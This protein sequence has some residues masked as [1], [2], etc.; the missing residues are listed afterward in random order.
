MAEETTFQPIRWVDRFMRADAEQP[1]STA[2]M[3]L[4]A[5]RAN[6]WVLFEWGKPKEKSQFYVFKKKEVLPRL[7]IVPP[8]VT[9]IR[10]LSL[11]SGPPSQAFENRPAGL[12]TATQA[13]PEQPWLPRKVLLDQVGKPVAI[14][15]P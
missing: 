10:A 14:G 13:N 1:A 4:S 11:Q 6:Q 15:I 2:R 8:D 12:F 9:V 7:E 3:A 5:L